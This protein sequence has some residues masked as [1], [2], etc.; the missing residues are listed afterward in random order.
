MTDCVAAPNLD[1]ARFA[2]P[3]FVQL[4]LSSELVLP[5]FYVFHDDDNRVP[6][7]SSR[8]PG[9]HDVTARG[10]GTI[11]LSRVPSNLGCFASISQGRRFCAV[12]LIRFCTVYLIRFCA[13]Y[14]IFVSFRLISPHLP[15]GHD[16]ARGLARGAGGGIADVLWRWQ[17]GRHAPASPGV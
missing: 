5:V 11:A 3:P 1:A 15:G 9:G 10:F 8:L 6:S 16:L 7:I 17:R 14:L 13:V 2:V 4:I 12:Y